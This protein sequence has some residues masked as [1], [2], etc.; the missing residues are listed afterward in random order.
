[1]KKLSFLGLLL[2]G[3]GIYGQDLQEV[4]NA[5]EAEQ[6]HKAKN[7]LKNLIKNKADRGEN[8]YYLADLYIAANEIDSAQIYLQKGVNVK[9]NAHYNYIGLGHLDL[10][11]KNVQAA[12]VNFEKAVAE[13]KKKDIDELVQIGR[14]YIN[15]S[16]P[17]PKKSIEY[18][19]K[20][21]Q[22]N[23]KSAEAYMYLG[24]AYLADKN[25]N[26][27]FKAYREASSLDKGLTRAKMQMAVIT[28]NAK[29]FAEAV[30]AFEEIV[31][32]NP[33]Y[34]PVYRELAETYHYWGTEESKK[35][36]EYNQ[37]ALEYYKKYMNLT[38]TSLDSRMRYADFLI[39]TKDYE[40]LEKEAQKMQTEKNINPRIYRYLGYASYQNDKYA[41][42]AEA[43][44]T[45][46]QKGNKIIGRDYLFLGKSELALAQSEDKITDQALF[47]KAIA[48]F[49][50]SVEV[51]P[52][53]SSEFSEI[54]QVF[55]KNKDYKTATSIFALAVKDPKSKTYA[56]DNLYLGN[57]ILFYTSSIDNL[58]EDKEAYSL[59]A[60]ADKAYMEV[61]TAAPTTQDAY[62]N[63][64]KINRL[65]DT[66]ESLLK[67]V[68]AYEG[69]LK[70]VSDKGD[71]EMNKERTKREMLSGYM[72]L[73]SRYA[74]TDKAKAIQN[75]EKALTLNPSE[76]N[77]KY[78]KQSI[79]VLKK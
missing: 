25:V 20:A 18:L 16:H 76:E 21:V 71:A 23:P 17:N 54:G 3:S 47:N 33:N 28:K 22:T 44:N 6:F 74:L 39:L 66:P 19:T 51:D 30:A 59:L 70:V 12:T 79:E 31:K 62:S 75:F 43:L 52:A 37:K 24:D 9:S 36:K 10:N 58:K 48:N 42:A 77:E 32:S 57:A 11:Q 67:A 61:I 8:Y 41:Q 45:Y 49:Q 15:A 53:L 34:G 64:A 35:Y 50:K 46:L 68:E 13:I 7:I 65:I 14:A 2:L 27:A 1:M 60:D 72:Y 5:I 40:T 38:D 26:E 63:R 56:L 55:Y 78:I 29:A 73:G 4:K 69:Y